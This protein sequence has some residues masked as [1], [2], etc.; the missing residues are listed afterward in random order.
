MCP[1]EV[2]VHSDIS[3]TCILCAPGPCQASRGA[4]SEL[5]H[6]CPLTLLSLSPPEGVSTSTV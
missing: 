4:V 5:I 1:E 3:D 6:R 2:G